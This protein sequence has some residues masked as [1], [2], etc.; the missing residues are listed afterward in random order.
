MTPPE[1]QQLLQDEYKKLSQYPANAPHT[2]LHATEA[3]AQI[4]IEQNK[5]PDM[6]WND[7][8]PEVCCASISEVIDRAFS[9]GDIEIGEIMVIQRAIR[10]ENVTVRL[11]PD[12]GAPYNCVYEIVPGVPT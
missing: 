9:S 6:F 3:A 1:I 8:D 2:K 4:L 11:V 5:Q 7:N 12:T 10:M